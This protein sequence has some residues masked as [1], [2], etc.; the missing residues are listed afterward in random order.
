M[1]EYLADQFD[2]VEFK[3][4]EP[5][6]CDGRQ[7][8][9]YGGKIATGHMCRIDKRGPWRRVYVMIYSNSGS[10]Y[11]LVKGARFF[12]RDFDIPQT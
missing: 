11:V 9:G 6:W 12:V 7:V 5:P 10:A 3:Q 2:S 4:V 1:S 8:D